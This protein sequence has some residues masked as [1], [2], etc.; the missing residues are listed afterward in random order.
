MAYMW[1]ECGQRSSPDGGGSGQ[2]LVVCRSPNEPSLDSARPLLLRKPY[3]G[4]D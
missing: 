2:S 4:G 3:I 1:A